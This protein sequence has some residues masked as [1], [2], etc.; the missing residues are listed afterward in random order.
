VFERAQSTT[1]VPLGV[2]GDDSSGLIL[3]AVDARRGVLP[4]AGE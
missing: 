4:I 3:G 1:E 2:G